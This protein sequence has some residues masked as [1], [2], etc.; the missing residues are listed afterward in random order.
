MKELG[1]KVQ[2]NPNRPKDEDSFYPKTRICYGEINK[3]FSWQGEINESRYI[4]KNH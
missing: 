2:Y 1:Y 4:N 3:G